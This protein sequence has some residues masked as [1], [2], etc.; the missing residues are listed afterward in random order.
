MGQRKKEATKQ[1][2]IRKLKAIIEEQKETME[3]IRQTQSMQLREENRLQALQAQ[4]VMEQHMESMQED[5]R[6]IKAELREIHG[7]TKATSTIVSTK[8]QW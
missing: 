6:V 5:M 8:W 7:I 4:S 3:Q 2:Q 1:E